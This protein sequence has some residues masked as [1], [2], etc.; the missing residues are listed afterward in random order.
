MRVDEVETT[1]FL[2]EFG[3]KGYGP[4]HQEAVASAMSAWIQ[5]DRMGNSEIRTEIYPK[6]LPPGVMGMMYMRTNIYVLAR[7]IRSEQFF[8]LV[9]GTAA[10]LSADVSSAA[11]SAAATEIRALWKK[12]GRLNEE[13]GEAARRLGQLMGGKSIYEATVDL[14][15]YVSNWPAGEEEIAKRLLEELRQIGIV[16]ETTRGWTFVK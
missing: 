7:Q 1:R 10:M 5:E 9:A 8:V 15:T 2:D 6:N 16:K 13:Q 3:L 4:E 12:V 14:D 11:V